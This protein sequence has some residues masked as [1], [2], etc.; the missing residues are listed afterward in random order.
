MSTRFVVGIEKLSDNQAIALRKYF[1]AQ[2]SWWNWIPGF[3]LVT[4]DKETS[5]DALR[6]KIMEI[7][8]NKDC[9]I[10][11]AND[12]EWSGFGP[13]SGEQNMFTWMKETWSSD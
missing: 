2:G 13:G 3:W 4:C 11:S 5:A 9:M 8:P 12:T 6:D 1:L 7:A 10:I